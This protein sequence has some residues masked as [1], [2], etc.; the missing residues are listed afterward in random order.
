MTL[1]CQSQ[2][3]SDFEALH[4]VK[5]QSRPYVTIN[6][7]RKAYVGSPLVWLHLTLVNLKENLKVTHDFESVYLVKRPS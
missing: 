6:I 3:H 4:I 2:G 7:N 5:Q 1:K